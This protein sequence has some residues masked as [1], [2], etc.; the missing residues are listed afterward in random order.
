MFLILSIG[1][2]FT[3]VPEF[4]VSFP[5]FVLFEDVLSLPVGS[6]RLEQQVPILIFENL[7]KSKIY[8][9]MGFWGFGV[10]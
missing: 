1:L 4:L 2:N 10:L 5:P 6:V 8:R 3:A 7:N 9:L